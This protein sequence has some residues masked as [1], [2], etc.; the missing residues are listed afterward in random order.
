MPALLPVPDLLLLL[1]LAPLVTAQAPQLDGQP[2]A[3]RHPL[4]HLPVPLLPLAAAQLL[5]QHST[6][7]LVPPRGALLHVRALL[8]LSS[9]LLQAA[10]SALLEQLP[11]ALLMRV[12]LPSQCHAR[13][14]RLWVNTRIASASIGM[15]AC[16]P[17]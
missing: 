13:H 10:W 11:L 6:H 15:Q 5:Q 8:L 3:C 12:L 9:P 17:K 14:W 4:L 7:Q 2:A 16:H 1:L